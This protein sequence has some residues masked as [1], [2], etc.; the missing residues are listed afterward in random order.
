MGAGPQWMLARELSWEVGVLPE[1][2][3]RRSRLDFVRSLDFRSL[4]ASILFE[5]WVEG[6]LNVAILLAIRIPRCQ[7]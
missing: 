6:D 3:N 7:R 2:I 5:R 4:I 1:G